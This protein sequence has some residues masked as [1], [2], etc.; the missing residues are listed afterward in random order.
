MSHPMPSHLVTWNDMIANPEVEKIA[1]ANKK[2]EL[3]ETCHKIQI[4]GGCL[5]KDSILKAALKCMKDKGSL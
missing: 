2:F 4:N 1:D 5:K 3:Y